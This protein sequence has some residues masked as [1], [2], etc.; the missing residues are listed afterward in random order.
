MF[1]EM[2]AE[3][4]AAR[5]LQTCNTLSER[6]RF[7]KCFEWCHSLLMPNNNR[8]I[9][10]QSVGTS[11]RTIAGT[12]SDWNT[13]HVGAFKSEGPRSEFSLTYAEPLCSSVE[14]YSAAATTFVMFQNW[15]D[16]RHAA[17]NPVLLSKQCVYA[18]ACVWERDYEKHIKVVH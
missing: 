3:R 13:A 1:L 2:A 10:A 12:C 4:S 15:R 18:R 5:G 8:L 17:Q 14:G 6:L 16:L 9:T 7:T 11:W